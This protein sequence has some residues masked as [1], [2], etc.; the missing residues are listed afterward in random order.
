MYIHGERSFELEDVGKVK[1][2]TVQPTNF[3]LSSKALEAF[4]II[5]DDWEMNVCQKYPH[6]PFIGGKLVNFTCAYQQF[7]FSKRA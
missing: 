6:D 2:V 7:E 4:E 1:H 5:H 3:T